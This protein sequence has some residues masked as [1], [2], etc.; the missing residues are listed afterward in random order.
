MRHRNSRSGQGYAEYGFIILLVAVFVIATVEA[1]GYD[2][3]D[4][5]DETA[6]N[7]QLVADGRGGEARGT[8]GYAYTPPSHGDPE[9]GP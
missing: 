5:Y 2:V 9:S 4:F 3:S 1:F 7:V 6:Y 8:T